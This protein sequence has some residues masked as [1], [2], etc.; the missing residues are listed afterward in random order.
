V[1]SNESGDLLPVDT[2]SFDGDVFTSDSTPGS[3]SWSDTGFDRVGSSS[4]QNIYRMT[5]T[6]DNPIT[7]QPGEYWFSHDAYIVPEPGT[8]VLL[9]MASLACLINGRRRRG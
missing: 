7:L 1:W 4:T 6:L 5:Y 9:G 2:G 8:L 3:F